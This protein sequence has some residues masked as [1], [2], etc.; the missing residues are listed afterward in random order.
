MIKAEVSLYPAISEE[1][2]ELTGLSNQFLHEHALDYDVRTSQLSFDTTII[3]DADHVW[4]AIRRLFKDN[5]DRGNDVV[6][7][8]TLFKE[9]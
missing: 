3:G 6:M 2:N 8:A 1:V 9:D 4:T 7:I 5:H